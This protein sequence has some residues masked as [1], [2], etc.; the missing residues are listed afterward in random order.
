[1]SEFTP[2]SDKAKSLIEDSHNLIY[3]VEV[4]PQK[5]IEEL[6]KKWGFGKHSEI[7]D[8]F[9]YSV[10]IAPVLARLSQCPYIDYMVNKYSIIDHLLF[11]TYIRRNEDPIRFKRCFW[12]VNSYGI[13][14]AKKITE[15]IRE[16]KVKLPKVK[17][18]LPKNSLMIILKGPYKLAHCEFLSGFLLGSIK[19]SVNV[20]LLLLDDNVESVEHTIRNSKNIN[21]ISIAS[22]KNTLDKILTYRSIVEVLEPCN[23]IWTA[24]VQNLTL[25]MG[26]KICN[27]MTYWSMK[28]HS[29]IMPSLSHYAGLGYGGSSFI[30]DDVEWFRGRAF[31]ALYENKL[32]EKEIKRLKEDLGINENKLVA[33]CYVRSEKLNDE[34]LWNT[35]NSIL[36][37]NES[38]IFTMAS[39]SL[40]EKLREKLKTHIQSKRFIYLGWV[41]TKRYINIADMYLDSFPRGSCNT[42]FEACM[43]GKPFV[44]YDSDLNRESSALPYF[45]SQKESFYGMVNNARV[46]R[47]L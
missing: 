13:L 43:A 7:W 22:T 40:P 24:C 47:K 25:Y 23:I 5:G 33:A 28:Y 42:I 21:V 19:N 44:V 41:D 4:N 34:S 39:Q 37:D 1:M 6:T 20:N 14:I 17:T 18:R 11:T 36:N 27:K 10:V 26:D 3:E 8:D 35:I 29:I 15:N 32:S 12:M 46:T 2:A 16:N 31:P 45:A 30:Y 38:L 9:I